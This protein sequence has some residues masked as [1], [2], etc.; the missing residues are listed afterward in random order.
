M[1]GEDI[2]ALHDCIQR[3]LAE[4]GDDRYAFLRYVGEKE[5][6]GTVS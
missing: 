1:K 3:R 4:A 2:F 5:A 6:R